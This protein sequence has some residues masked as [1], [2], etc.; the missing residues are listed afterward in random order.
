MS[1]A[2][3]FLRHLRLE[4]SGVGPLD[5]PQLMSKRWTAHL[6]RQATRIPWRKFIDSGSRALVG[7]TARFPSPLDGGSSVLLVPFPKNQTLVA[8]NLRIK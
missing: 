5:S 1:L 7:L 8:A 2:V 3:V 6:V 4:G